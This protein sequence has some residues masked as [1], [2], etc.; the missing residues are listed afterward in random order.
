MFTVRVRATN[1]DN[2]P[3]T[4]LATVT[5]YVASEPIEGEYVEIIG[6]AMFKVTYVDANTI[7]GRAISPV[8]ADPNCAELRQV[9]RARLIPWT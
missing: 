7:S 4:R 6:F 5:L 2:Q 1:S 3:V 8:C 9:Q